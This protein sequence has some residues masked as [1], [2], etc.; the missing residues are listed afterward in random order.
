[1]EDSRKIMSHVNQNQIQINIETILNNEK[2][3]NVY[4]IDPKITWESLQQYRKTSNCKEI[5]IILDKF[6]SINT[7]PFPR[8]FWD[9]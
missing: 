6:E 9:S 1:M 3:E 8:G 5:N 4:E 7:K 2:D